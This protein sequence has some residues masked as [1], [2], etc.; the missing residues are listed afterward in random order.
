VSLVNSGRCSGALIQ[1]FKQKLEPFLA[2]QL[3]VKRAISFFSLGETPNFLTAL[4]T[5]LN[6]K[7]GSDSFWANLIETR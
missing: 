3:F 6:Y 1:Q 4:F 5:S 2:G 7:L